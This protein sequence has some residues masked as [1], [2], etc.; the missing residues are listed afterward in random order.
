MAVITKI[1]SE[2][3]KRMSNLLEQFAYLRGHFPLERESLG[4]KYM[5]YN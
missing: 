2:G 3:F 5:K 4:Y 1:P